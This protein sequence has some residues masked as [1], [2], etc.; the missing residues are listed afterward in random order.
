[1]S[2]QG[3]LCLP[4]HSCARS[5]GSDQV[6]IDA[7]RQRF[8]EVMNCP[9]VG[10]ERSTFT[11]LVFE[12]IPASVQTSFRYQMF[13]L[14]GLHCIYRNGKAWA[15]WTLWKLCKRYACSGSSTSGQYLPRPDV[16][17]LVKF[18]WRMGRSPP[19]AVQC[20]CR[21]VMHNKSHKSIKV[22]YSAQHLRSLLIK[23]GLFTYSTCT[24][25][26]LLETPP[27]TA[28]NTSEA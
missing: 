1:M 6:C 4:C 25:S 12:H 8:E 23:S 3:G 10:Y 14:R 7:K 18:W 22:V 20:V 13:G 28:A 5:T 9:H 26:V 19:V 2:V 11:S 27:S 16:S 21:S 15:Q 17:H 24:G